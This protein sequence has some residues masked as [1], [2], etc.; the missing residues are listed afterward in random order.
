M[1][2]VCRLAAEE[3]KQTRNTASV[4]QESWPRRHKAD[5]GQGELDERGVC[6]P[7]GV[8][9]RR[10]NLQLQS[11]RSCLASDFVVLVLSPP[12][13]TEYEYEKK[14]EQRCAPK[15]AQVAW[16]HRFEEFGRGVIFF[17]EGQF[18]GGC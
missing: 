11:M 3:K 14:H 4:A 18:D 17:G 13:R 16:E 7:A 15:S 12:G 1:H 10:R 9:R 8:P 5:G 6:L 2:L